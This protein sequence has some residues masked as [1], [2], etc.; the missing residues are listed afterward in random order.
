M[1]VSEFKCSDVLR[2]LIQQVV[3]LMLTSQIQ[4]SAGLRFPYCAHS[5]HTT[6]RSCSENR[7]GLNYNYT[8][9]SS[10]SPRNAD[11]EYTVT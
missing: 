3:Y 11:T 10:L 6:T 8:C 5:D 2:S 9:S 1:A 7:K 4:T